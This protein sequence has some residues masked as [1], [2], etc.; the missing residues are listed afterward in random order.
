MNYDKIKQELKDYILEELDCALN[1]TTIEDKLYARNR[2]YGALMFVNNQV[3]PHDD[4]LGEWWND[5]IRPK[6]L[7]YSKKALDKLEKS[8]YNK[9][10]R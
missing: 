8:M 1:A 2:A 7:K 9:G 6:F 3:F 10:I 5:E 4:K